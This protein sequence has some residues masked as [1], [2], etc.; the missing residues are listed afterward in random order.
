MDVTWYGRQDGLVALTLRHCPSWHGPRSAKSLFRF[1]FFPLLSAGAFGSR[2]L[3]SS[4]PPSLQ[5]ISDSSK[6]YHGNSTSPAPSAWTQ[7]VTA[8]RRGRLTHSTSTATAAA[9]LFPGSASSQ[10]PTTPSSTMPP[11]WL[12]SVTSLTTAAWP[13]S[14][15]AAADLGGSGRGTGSSSASWEILLLLSFSVRR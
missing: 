5:P 15:T 4:P 7:N 13:T 11:D 6:S 14:S 3:V 8:M 2:H 1:L 10:A 9:G 12:T